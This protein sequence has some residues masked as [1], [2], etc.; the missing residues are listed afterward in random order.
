[1]TRTLIHMIDYSDIEIGYKP[2]SWLYVND[3]PETKENVIAFLFINDW[4]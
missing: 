4:K 1:M 3:R 2:P